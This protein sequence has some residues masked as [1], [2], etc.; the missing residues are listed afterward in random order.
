MPITIKPN[1]GLEGFLKTGT[2]WFKEASFLVGCYG[3][4]GTK[5][6]EAHDCDHRLY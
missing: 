3:I 6:R 2:W 5:G 4:L 1:D